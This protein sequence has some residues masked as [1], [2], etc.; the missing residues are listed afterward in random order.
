MKESGGSSDTNY[1]PSKEL[2]CWSLPLPHGLDPH[3]EEGDRGDDVG[4][5][6]DSIAIASSR[7]LRW[8]AGVRV[9]AVFVPSVE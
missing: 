9:L 2:P 7:T 3:Y 1:A 5:P 4:R 8:N 6:L